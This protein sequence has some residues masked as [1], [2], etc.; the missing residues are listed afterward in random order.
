MI[1]DSALFVSDAEIAASED[2]LHP[3]LMVIKSLTI[4]AKHKMKTPPPAERKWFVTWSLPTSQ[5]A[6]ATHSASGGAGDD[7]SIGAALA[8][9]CLKIR[10]S[11]ALC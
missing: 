11:C 4:K 6:V 10:V 2:L 5:A 8:S 7:S 9:E 1:D 3:G